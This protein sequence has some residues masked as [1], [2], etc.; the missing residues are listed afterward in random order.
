MQAAAKI[1][2]QQVNGQTNYRRAAPIFHQEDHRMHML[3]VAL[4]YKH[5][6]R[7]LTCTIAARNVEELARQCGVQ[8]IV[9]I[10]D[11]E[12]TR[13]AVLGAVRQMTSKCGPDDVFI[14]YFAG[15]GTHRE[16]ATGQATEE[17]TFVLV[18]RNGQVSASTLL[19]GDD[20]AS[21]ILE[22]CKHETRILILTDT[23]FS[24]TIMDLGRG[25]WTGRQAT[26]LS[27]TQDA[28]CTEED[29]GAIF[30]HAVLLAIDKLSKVG[31]E[32]Y[33]V[34]MLYNAALHEGDIVFSGKQDIIIQA[35][36]RFSA[37]QLAW[38]LVPPDG[39]QAPLSRCAR[40]GGIRSDA[41]KLGVSP[42]L[43]QHVRQEALNVPVSI[44]EYVSYVQGHSL[45][46]LKPCRACSAGY[47]GSQCTVQ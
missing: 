11:D 14:F 4:D 7:P 30:T 29:R 6:G 45:F 46:Q 43:L 47:S 34:G 40:P 31:R 18:D 27:G 32:N 25:A 38:P 24:G 22:G 10:Y 3:I 28:R 9:P 26:L 2:N 37:D 23:T 16:D 1:R 21:A 17:E 33:S 36:P 44:E 41:A 35:A 20:L 42:V 13:D 19:R 12:C 15:H 39:Y 5:T 8:W